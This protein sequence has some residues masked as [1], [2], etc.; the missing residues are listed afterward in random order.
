MSPLE[1]LVYIIV[2]ST[3]SARVTRLLT[4]DRITDFYRKPFLEY[5]ETS[6]YYEPKGMIGYLLHCNW[7]MGIWCTTFL[8]IIL[9]TFDVALYPMMILSAS[10]IQG[11]LNSIEK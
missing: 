9:L 2:L 1:I 8:G 7:C 11:L 10:Y 6:D 5:N 4:T 3:A